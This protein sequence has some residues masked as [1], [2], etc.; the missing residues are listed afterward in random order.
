MYRRPDSKMS[1]HPS[2][3]STNVKSGR[4]SPFKNGA[5]EQKSSH[6]HSSKKATKISRNMYD[7]S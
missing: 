7:N 3:M 6:K 4:N 2:H 5:E 1:A